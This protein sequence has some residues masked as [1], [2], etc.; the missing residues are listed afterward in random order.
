MQNFITAIRNLDI[1]KVAGVLGALTLVEMAI[2]NGEIS[3]ADALPAA[4]IPHLV[5]WCKI[6]VIINNA[7]LIG[8]AG[9]ALQ[10]PATKVPAAAKTAA[11]ALVALVALGLG[12]GHPAYAASAKRPALTGNP[13]ADISSALSG[14]ASSGG[15]SSA[16]PLAALLQQIYD[17]LHSTGEAV[18]AD[19]VKAQAVAAAKFAD[20]TVADQ[21]SNQCLAAVIP[22]AQLIV[23][24]QLVPAGVTAAAP[25]GT[26]VAAADAGAPDGLITAFVKVRVVVN[27]LQSPSLQSGCAWL[28]SSLSEGGASGLA[29]ILAGFVGLK[30]LPAIAAGVL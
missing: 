12:F 16:D 22:V 7:L 2:A 21:P 24:N 26:A 23:E 20:G 9:T 11:A 17:K 6:C 8:H 19:M 1:R 3:F 15:A 29:N 14:A 25:G 30:S 10:W 5:A 28:Q 4:W 18:I 13:V 27:A